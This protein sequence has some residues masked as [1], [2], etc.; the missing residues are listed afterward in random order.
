MQLH[1]HGEPVPAYAEL[2]KPINQPLRRPGSE[3]VSPALAHKQTVSLERACHATP[4][5]GVNRGLVY[6]SD[7]LETS[8]LLEVEHNFRSWRTSDCREN[9]NASFVVAC[10]LVGFD[11]VVTVQC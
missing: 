9:C 5:N 4:A 11:I 1:Q 8:S 3:A 2:C 10:I 7:S 6:P